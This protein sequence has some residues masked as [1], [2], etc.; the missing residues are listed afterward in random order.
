MPPTQ[1][2]QTSGNYRLEYGK[3]FN[4][5]WLRQYYG[6]DPADGLAL[7]IQDPNQADDANTRTIDGVKM[8]LNPSK[9][10]YAYS[11]S[12]LPKAYGSITNN[13]DY[14]GFYLDALVTY[15]WGGKVYDGNYATLMS[16]NPNGN[17]VHV[18][19]LKAWE[20]PG[21]I[22]DVPKLT[23]VNTS[24]A[25]AASTRWL[26]SSDYVSLKSVTI[27]YKFN[28]DVIKD[29]GMTG[30]RMYVTGENLWAKTSMQGLEP[31]QSV[32]GGTS[33]RYIP[34]RIITVGLNASF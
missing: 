2:V 17:A 32:G 3:S 31:A 16:A 24:F 28:G 1:Q 21:D 4:D 29:L 19:I 9:A 15:Q 13:F 22:T 25:T 33:Y 10:L 12:S 23:T 30:L 8:N 26:K 18:D 27:G 20:K 14:K 34:S 6:V 7:Y 5:F 11:G